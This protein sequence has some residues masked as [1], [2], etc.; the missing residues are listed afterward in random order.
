V[1]IWANTLTPALR[2]D[3]TVYAGNT[4]TTDVLGQ[5]LTLTGQ[6]AYLRCNTPR[7]Q[8]G[9]PRVDVA[10]I[11]FDTGVSP[12]T[13]SVFSNDT[14]DLTAQWNLGGA[15]DDDGDALLYLGAP[16]NSSVNFFKGPY[17]YAGTVA[18]ASAATIA[19]FANLAIASDFSIAVN[20]WVPWRIRMTYD[21]GRL[22]QS[23]SG[24]DQVTLAA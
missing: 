5:S 23:L 19:S 8:A 13:L 18:V 2:N 6:Q 22:S 10:P 20:A 14:G 4:P 16:Q 15:T 7:L 11:I 1:N 17:Q 21:D 9:L 3:W 24:I 12:V